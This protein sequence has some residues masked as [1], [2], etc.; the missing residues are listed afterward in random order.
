MSKRNLRSRSKKAA[1]TRETGS[2]SVWYP[3]LKAVTAGL[4]FLTAL[5]LLFSFL[6]TKVD[7]PFSLIEPATLVMDALSCILAGFLAARAVRQRGLLIGGACGLLI[8]CVLLIISFFFSDTVDLQ[9]LLKM[10]VCT[11][12]G[13]IG[14][15]SGVNAKTRRR[16]KGAK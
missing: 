1:K 8:G 2:V 6:L 15:V 13:A 11:L 7:L 4:F 14:G 16:I 9:L 10:T 5:L 12:G 3:M